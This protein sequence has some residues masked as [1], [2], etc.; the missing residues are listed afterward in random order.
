MRHP[1]CLAHLRAP[2]SRYGIRCL[3]PSPSLSS[4][5]SLAL[6]TKGESQ[7]IDRLVASLAARVGAQVK[8]SHVMRA[9][10]ALLLH[11]EGK[12]EKGDAT[13]FIIVR[14][15]SPPTIEDSSFGHLLPRLGKMVASPFSA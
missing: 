1:S 3:F 15:W 9:L 14:G 12:L 8:V 7:D 5:L 4:L 13:L 6:F 10:V 2:S 11:A